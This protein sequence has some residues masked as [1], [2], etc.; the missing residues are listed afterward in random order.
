MP[1]VYQEETDLQRGSLV[2]KSK[3]RVAEEV[4]VILDVISL[5]MAK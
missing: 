3:H 1:F 2:S 4:E 5:C